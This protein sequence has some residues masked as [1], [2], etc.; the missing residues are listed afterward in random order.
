MRLCISMCRANH[1][2][3]SCIRRQDAREENRKNE[4]QPRKERKIEIRLIYET[5][6]NA[7]RTKDSKRKR[8]ESKRKSVMY[9]AEPNGLLCENHF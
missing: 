4:N 8:K 6:A 7:P 2:T 3:V 5:C 9:L 1:Q